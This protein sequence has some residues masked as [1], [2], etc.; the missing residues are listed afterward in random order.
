[1]PPMA[2]GV[3][4]AA[5]AG[6]DRSEV[7]WTSLPVER[8]TRQALLAPR[9]KVV[10]VLGLVIEATG[11]AAAVGDLC[12]IR[13]SRGGTD[14][15]AEIAG[16]RDNRLLLMPLGDM[17]G[18]APG[19]EVTPLG[20]PLTVPAGLSLLGRVLDGVG[21]PIDGRGGLE[22]TASVPSRSAPPDPLAR[23][24][25]AEPLATGVRALDALL[26]VGL[27]Q[28]IGIFAGS[29]VG[30]STLLGMIARR[31]EADVNVIG[32]IGER[33]REVREFIERDLGAEGLARSVLVVATSDAP[34]QIRRQAAFTATAIAEWFRDQGRRVLLMMDS[35]TRFATA[36]R[37]VGLA[38]GE[39]PT[40]R[41]Y[42]PSVFALLPRLLER[43]GTSPGRGAI[44]GLYTILVEGDDHNEPVADT[45]RSILDGHV[46]LTR[47]LAE[48]GHYP[49][50]DVL[51]SV[52]RC[53]PDVVT[54]EHLA[55]AQTLR[56]L[57]AARRE[58][59]PLLALGAYQAGAR[60]QTDRA[61]K[62]WDEIESYLRQTVDE[63]TSFEATVQR[64][65]R[66]GGA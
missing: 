13:V 62:A 36:Q 7:A 57:I 41:G 17:E 12:R 61:I 21:R 48:R 14:V 37:E 33:G 31:T 22:A 50:V 59:E 35:L 1:M 30:K 11:P 46:V 40:T 26:T 29:G 9:G 42:T 32:L 28:R 8:L 58:V 60:P 45:A 64:L 2:A 53:M 6:R 15:T 51:A 56:A 52:S 19:A 25:V 34:P 47:E 4:S 10:K 27:G 18:V 39:P 38:V 54:P 24:R 5:P 66:L 65:A 43:A 55:H 44:T 3:G 49:A 16:F 20:R 63:S 23:Q